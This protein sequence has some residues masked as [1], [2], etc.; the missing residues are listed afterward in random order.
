MSSLEAL[1]L[2]TKLVGLDDPLQPQTLVCSNYNSMPNPVSSTTGVPRQETDGGWDG[3]GDSWGRETTKLRRMLGR[4]LEARAL[5]TKLGHAQLQG[6]C[7]CVCDVMSLT[8][9]LCGCVTER[10]TGK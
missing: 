1:D 10:E 4:E 7:V 2:S 3:R 6:L 5:H 9:C 8:E